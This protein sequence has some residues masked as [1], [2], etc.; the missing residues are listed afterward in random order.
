MSS[1]YNCCG[2]KFNYL[3]L[4]LKHLNEHKINKNLLIMCNLCGQ[5]STSLEYFKKHNQ[6]LHSQSKIFE[7][8]KTDL[9][10]HL[11]LNEDNECLINNN[12]GSFLKILP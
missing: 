5:Y 9:N 3:N 2:I 12:D 4:Y 8:L 10:T 7:F 11:N 6:K 1:I